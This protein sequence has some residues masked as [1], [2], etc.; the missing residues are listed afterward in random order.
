MKLAVILLAILIGAFRPV[1]LFYEFNP[2]IESGYEAAAHLFTG[3]LV[4]CWLANHKFSLGLILL[5]LTAF[6]RSSE[7]WLMR[8][9]SALTAVEII[10]V[11]IG[12]AVKRGSL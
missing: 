4:G 10:C 6:A 5:L 3:G 8:T 7:S 1:L 2:H 9:A 12:I 11:G